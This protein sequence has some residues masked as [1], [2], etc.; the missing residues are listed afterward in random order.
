MTRPGK[1]RVRRY[2]EAYTSFAASSTSSSLMVFRPACIAN[3]FAFLTRDAMYS[4]DCATSAA[5]ASLPTRSAPLFLAI[6]TTAARGKSATLIT[7]SEKGFEQYL[8]IALEFTGK[9]GAT[10]FKQGNGSNSCGRKEGN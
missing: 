9:E 2:E 6:R 1:R 4:S 10:R 5:A 3:V 8:Y 7:S